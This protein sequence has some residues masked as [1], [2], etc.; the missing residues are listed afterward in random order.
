MR[1]AVFILAAVL[2]L[3]V[4]VPFV[5]GF[6]AAHVAPPLVTSAEMFAQVAAELQ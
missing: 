3:I 2:V 1:T 4:G 5:R 6:Q